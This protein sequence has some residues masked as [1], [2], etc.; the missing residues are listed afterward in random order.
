MIT[1]RRSPRTLL[2]LAAGGLLAG[3][4]APE[5]A[6]AQGREGFLLREPTVALGFQMGYAVPD[7]SSEIFRFVEDQLTVERSD[8]NAPSLGGFLAVRLGARLD[9][10]VDV[11]FSRAETRSEFRDWVDMDDLPIEQETYLQRVPLTLGLT[12]YLRDRGR[13][14]G[15]FA[16]IPTDWNG[17]LGAGAGVT[18]YEFEQVGDFVDFETLD[19]F[20]EAYRN[21][22]STPT[23]HVYGGVE[24]SLASRLLLTVEGRYTWTDPVEM[25]GD[26]VGFEPMDLSG[27]QVSVGFAARF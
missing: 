18:W 5:A 19:I 10:R 26:F 22:G 21:D 1:A 9:A 13:T 25:R 3:G 11:S 23:A 17:Y 16:W 2:A 7:A 8:F 15:R 20:S 6:T 4:L 27:F 14:V 24:R 12:W